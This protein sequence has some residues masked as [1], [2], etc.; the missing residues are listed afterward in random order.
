ML[1]QEFLERMKTLLQEEYP[2]FMNSLE[3]EAFKGL[4]I[5]ALKTEVENFF[6]KNPFTLR[7]IPWTT[8][9]FYYKEEEKPGKHPFH[10][11]GVYYIQEPSAMAPV[12]FLEVKP[13]ERVLDLC[14]A[15][16]RKSVV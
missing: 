3:G 14:A 4:R 15:P 11:A 2:L 10:D 8:C 9:G 1:P 16:D 6:E 5:N 13:G 12:T 7:E